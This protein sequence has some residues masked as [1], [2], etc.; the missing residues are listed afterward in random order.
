[1]TKF[2]SFLAITFVLSISSVEAA[3]RSRRVRVPAR[4][5]GKLRPPNL[6][7]AE[8]ARGNLQALGAKCRAAANAI[9]KEVASV[10]GLFLYA[11]TFV[12][13]LLGTK[14]MV[15]YSLP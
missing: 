4:L 1:M 2:I 8:I 7:H 6:E 3:R 13:R 15:Q 12:C 14:R 5:R 11:P 10:G 9:D